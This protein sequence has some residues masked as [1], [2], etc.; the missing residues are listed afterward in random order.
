MRASAPRPCPPSRAF[1]AIITMTVSISP[2]VSVV[3]PMS[4]RRGDGLHG[5]SLAFLAL[6][7]LFESFT[8]GFELFTF[9]FTQ[10]FLFFVVIILLRLGSDGDGVCTRCRPA[11]GR[12]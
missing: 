6:S 11:F 12:L 9:F 7:F 10:R 3:V 1:S 5:A 4:R 8:F 2:I